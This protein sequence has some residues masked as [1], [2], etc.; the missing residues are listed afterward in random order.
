MEPPFKYDSYGQKIWS[1]NGNLALDVRG[2][3]VFQYKKNNTELQDQFGEFVVK[4]LND[5][6]K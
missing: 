6:I 3:G 2:W 1:D 4:A 5:A